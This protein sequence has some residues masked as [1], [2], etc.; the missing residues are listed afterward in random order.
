M[1]LNLI[2]KKQFIFIIIII[3]IPILLKANDEPERK[4]DLPVGM[5]KIKIG[6][7]VII[8]PEDAKVTKNGS[9]LIIEDFG[10]YATRKFLEIEK[11]LNALELAQN[12]LEEK[13]VEL[14]KLI[15]SLENKISNIDN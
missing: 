10:E 7:Q 4:K 8:V 15:K 6:S 1:I 13:I 12:G 9:A 14:E 5:K 2:Q 11:R 3:S